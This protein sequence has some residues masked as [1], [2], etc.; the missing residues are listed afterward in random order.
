MYYVLSIKMGG[1]CAYLFHYLI[2]ILSIC[3]RLDT[4]Q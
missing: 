4:T 2:N 1:Y 3:H